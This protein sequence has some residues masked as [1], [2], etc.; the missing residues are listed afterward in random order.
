[1]ATH[2]TACILCS[3]NC[4]LETETEGT[5][6]TRIRGDADHPDSRGYICQKAAR[7]DHYQNHDDRLQRPLKRLPDGTFEAVTWDEAL[8]DIADRLN[9]VRE[10]HGSDAFALCGGGGQGNHLGALYS[11]QLLA[12]MDSKFVYSSLAQEKTGDFWVNGRLFGKQNCHV[13]EGVE[14]ADYVVFIGTNPF[15][16]HGIPN[17]RE[18]LRAIKKDPHRTMVVIDPRRTETVKWADLHLQVKPGMDAFLIGA[19][20][21]VIVQN[22]WH[23]REFIEKHCT[24]FESVEAELLKVSAEDYA[25]RAGVSYEEVETVA[26]GISHARTASVRVDLGTQQTLH[27][28]L[29]AWLEKLLYL[30]TG[31]FGRKGTNN[32]H[33]SLI[34]IIG[35]TD[36]RRVIEGKP[37][38]RT[39]HHQMMPIAGMYPPN[40]LPD[41][42]EQGGL[43]AIVVDSC[44]ALLSWPDTTALTRAFEKLDLLVVID[45]AM[46]ETARAADYVLPAASQFEKWEATGFN[47]EF[48]DNYF[49]LR[50]P[51]FEPLGDALP[52]AEIYTRLLERMGKIPEQFPVLESL[53]KTEP[54]FS[55]HGL[56]MTAMMWTMGR[57]KD[58][59]KFGASIL[60]RTLGK[61]LPDEAASA[62][63]L[64]PLTMQ[65][66]RTYPE[67]V[68]RAG[69]RGGFG[70]GRRTL[71]V[72][73]FRAILK[74]HSGLIISSHEYGE[75][76]DLIQT[77]D[78]RI[79]MEIPEMLEELAALASEQ[80]II[81][82][83]PFILMAGE[84]RS[85]NANQ[86]Y[87]DPEWRKIDPHGALRMHPDD[88]GEL[89]LA[90]GD[91]IV[92]RNDTGRIESV[93]EL[94]DGMRRGVTSLPHGYG[95]SFR[96]SEPIGPQI[97]RLTGSAHCDPLSKT[98]FHKY[99]QVSIEKASS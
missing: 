57:R 74:S 69:Q 95:M 88:A 16:A 90:N 27:T 99:V 72:K 45:V 84:R 23:D 47:L 50:K 29:N 96:G 79:H 41:E 19:M 13:S 76:W 17:A 4:G 73:L 62:A 77:P 34:P 21:A 6:L 15:Q 18:T 94:D 67:Q 20:L 87:R 66:A 54:D 81:D 42:I 14:H 8:A 97:N 75:G 12:A 58:L 55:C 92:C 1:M 53:A 38:R 44:N 56:F 98:P 25:K 5:R 65:F 32:L 82:D 39:K 51:V 70:G 89:G 40:I 43:R 31:H 91:P 7:L 93:V 83:H 28:T 9:Q 36:E 37:L 61:Q 46:T 10:M 63:P 3:R 30:V 48:P 52:E 59:R 26:R 33:T 86:I 78:G 24:G 71:G 64:L 68:R 22:G 60:Y 2:K 80:L 85:Y 35:N 49:H 11:Q